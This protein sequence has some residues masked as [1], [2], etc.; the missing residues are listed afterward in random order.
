MKKHE[1][2][3]NRITEIRDNGNTRITE[4]EVGYLSKPE[5]TVDMG[6]KWAIKRDNQATSYPISFQLSS[7]TTEL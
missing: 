1:Y 6:T 5:G 7:R 2:R 3:K 4:I